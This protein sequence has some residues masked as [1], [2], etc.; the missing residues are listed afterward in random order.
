MQGKREDGRGRKILERKIFCVLAK[1]EYCIPAENVRG[2]IGE[3]SYRN[4]VY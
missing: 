2:E 1:Q 3:I 4:L